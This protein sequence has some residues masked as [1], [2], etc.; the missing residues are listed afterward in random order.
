MDSLTI[1]CQ[2]LMSAL[3]TLMP[4]A[5]QQ[6]T[7]KALLGLF[8]K[9]IGRPLPEHCQVKSP[10]AISRFLNHYPWPTRQLIRSIRTWLLSQLL[11]WAPEAG[12][13]PSPTSDS[14]FNDFREDR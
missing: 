14:G 12:T 3:L 2:T 8:L 10:G 9:P 7:L 6:D 11:S 4:S 13:S 1:A 5:Y